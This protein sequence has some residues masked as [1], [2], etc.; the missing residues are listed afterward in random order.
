MVLDT[1][2]GLIPEP[3]SLFADCL[4]LRVFA[5]WRPGVACARWISIYLSLSIS[6]SVSNST[7]LTAL[8][9]CFVGCLSLG[10]FAGGRA[11]VP[12]ARWISIY[13]SL[14]MSTSVSNS[15][16]LTA[17]HFCF[18]DCLSLGVFAG[19]RAG[20]ARTRRGDQ[21]GRGSAQRKGKGRATARQC[22]AG[23]NGLCTKAGA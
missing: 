23:R 21:L 18:V 2:L 16:S 19:G 1:G 17:L 3:A 4:S 6:T 7:S 22:K 10:V 5:G 14:S 11:G 8:H 20:V 12:C 9:F 13:L 15:I